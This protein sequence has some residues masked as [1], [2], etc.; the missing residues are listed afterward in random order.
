MHAIGIDLGGTK[1]AAAVVTDTGEIVNK[2]V[3]STPRTADLIVDALVR[4]VSN[5]VS[6]SGI[7][8]SRIK[9]IGLGVPGP[10]DFKEQQIIKL[11]NIP[12]VTGLKIGDEVTKKTGIRTIID[13]DGILA[14][15]GEKAFGAAKDEDYVVMLTIGTGIGSG[16]IDKG[17]LVRGYRGT[18]AEIGHMVIKYDGPKCPCGNHG[19]IESLVSGPIIAHEARKRLGVKEASKIM[20]EE[21]SDVLKITPEVVIEGAIQGHAISGQII[22]EAATHLGVAISNILN[23]FNPKM[24]LIGGG[25]GSAAY[26]LMIDDIVSEAEKRA[27]P[28]N[29]EGVVFKSASLGPDA[30]ILGAAGLFLQNN[31]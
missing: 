17:V 6:K 19:C 15:W 12:S 24:I 14:C 8:P 22:K 1:V 25:F 20:G 9:G 16:I 27:L 4:I 3:A 23:I 13:N 18:G 2:F 29:F 10:V 7:E 31:R 26:D 5:L 11:T 30:G 28:P 21:I